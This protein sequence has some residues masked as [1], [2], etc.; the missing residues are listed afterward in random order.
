MESLASIV[1]PLWTMYTHS[2]H[3]VQSHSSSFTCL[4]HSVVHKIGPFGR[5][6]EL[7]GLF[8]NSHK[9]DCWLVFLLLPTG[10]QMFH[11]DLL[12][13]SS[14]GTLLMSSTYSKSVLWCCISI[15]HYFRVRSLWL[16][17]PV[18]WNKKKRNSHV[19]ENISGCFPPVSSTR[20]IS[21]EVNA[22]SKLWALS[23]MRLCGLEEMELWVVSF[24]KQLEGFVM[25]SQVA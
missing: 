19:L 14:S 2:T 12:Q 13:T 15:R 4:L 1:P 7:T 10:P 18:C 25:C 11:D 22:I 24:T 6:G 21:I 20:G 23:F 5:T 9:I 3:T 16:S 17:K 8:Y